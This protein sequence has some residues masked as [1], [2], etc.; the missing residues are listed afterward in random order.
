MQTTIAIGV[1]AFVVFGT[2]R[3]I[4]DHLEARDAEKNRLGDLR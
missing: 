4:F 1:L 3:L 2:L